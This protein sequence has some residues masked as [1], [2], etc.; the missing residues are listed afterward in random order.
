[1]ILRLKKGGQ[2]HRGP[3]CKRTGSTDPNGSRR[4]RVQPIGCRESWRNGGRGHVSI[5]NPPSPHRSEKLLLSTGRVQNERPASCAANSARTRM[6]S[7]CLCEQ[8]R[9]TL[10]NLPNS[11]STIFIANVP[12]LGKKMAD[13]QFVAYAEKKQQLCVRN[14]DRRGFSFWLGWALL[15]DR[16]RVGLRR[17]QLVR[18]GRG[19]GRREATAKKKLEREILLEIRVTATSDVSFLG[20]KGLLEISI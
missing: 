12:G 15:I 16:R 8:L 13:V 10:Q 19:G 18:G 11:A 1:M 5:N 2:G 20:K 9:M 7:K 17:R 14:T 4:A 6:E 3:G